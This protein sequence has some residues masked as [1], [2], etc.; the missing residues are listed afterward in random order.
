VPM[1]RKFL[2]LLPLA[3]SIGSL[4]QV[5][6][7]DADHREQTARVLSA[8]KPKR[9]T[10]I[11]TAQGTSKENLFVIDPAFNDI[12]QRLDFLASQEFKALA[13][14]R[15]VAV[16]MEDGENN[17]WGAKV[18]PDHF[19]PMEQLLKN[20]A[21]I[22]PSGPSMG[23]SLSLRCDGLQLDMIVP[24]SAAA[25]ASLRNGDYLVS[26]NARKVNTR[27]EVVD[28]LNREKG[29]DT[30]E[31]GMRRDGQMLSGVKHS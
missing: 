1:H 27:T 9:N 23:F 18:C 24:E 13:N 15:F 11:I 31:M 16:V 22:R 21:E 14:D 30:I 12:G 5:P 25:K 6:L 29:T 17:Y 28:F 8:T 19:S 4:A 3:I 20:G 10:R 2:L 26:L 7:T